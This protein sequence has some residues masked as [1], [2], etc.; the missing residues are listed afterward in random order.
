MLQNLSK[1]R[2]VV[3][4]DVVEGVLGAVDKV[5]EHHSWYYTYVHIQQYDIFDQTQQNQDQ[6]F[7][8]TNPCFRLD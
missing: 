3:I 4:H 5:R 1:G 7:C 6:D 8:V 2:M